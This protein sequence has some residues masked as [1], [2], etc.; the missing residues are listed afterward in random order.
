MGTP[1]QSLCELCGFTELTSVLN[2]EVGV[3][4]GGVRPVTLPIKSPTHTAEAWRTG[5]GSH[6]ENNGE[7][8]SGSDR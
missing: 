3:I 6:V 2:H 5:T 4:L 8:Y 1:L 7:V